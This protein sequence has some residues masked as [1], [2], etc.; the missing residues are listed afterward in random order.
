MK[1]LS[2]FLRHMVP[3]IKVIVVVCTRKNGIGA[4][5]KNGKVYEMLGKFVTGR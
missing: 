5:N 3:C 2:R 1:I 4:S